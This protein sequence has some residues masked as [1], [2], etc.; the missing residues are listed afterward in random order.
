MEER[1]IVELDPLGILGVP[2]D[3]LVDLTGRV[4]GSFDRDYG[5]EA[6]VLQVPR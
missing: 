3:K 4:G 6:H 5:R 1:V 2:D